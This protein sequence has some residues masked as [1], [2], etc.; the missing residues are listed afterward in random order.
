MIKKAKK[1]LVLLKVKQ[2]IL[3]H[4]GLNWSTKM[5]TFVLR[6]FKDLTANNY[7]VA[8]DMTDVVECLTDQIIPSVHC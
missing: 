7:V 5:I 3:W 6:Y 8:G 4:M 1:Y 2:I